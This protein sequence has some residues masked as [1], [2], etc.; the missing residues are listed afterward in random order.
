MMNSKIETHDVL[1]I[2]HS[3]CMDGF[4]SAWVAKRYFD[5]ANTSKPIKV[6]FIPGVYSN[7]PP[8]VKGKTVY[9]LDFSY[10]REVMEQIVRDA[11]KVIILDHH[12]TAIDRLETLEGASKVFDITRSGARITWDYFFP[13]EA[14]P[15]N[16]LHVEDRDLWKFNLPF[17]REIISAIF[18]YPYDFAVWDTLMSKDS[19]VL[20]AEGIH[21]ERKH[22]KDIN[23]LIGV[24]KRPMRIGGY[25]VNVANLPYTMSS[26]AGQILIDSGEPFGVCYYDTPEGRLFSLRSNGDF[27]VAK[28]AEQYG[29]GGHKNA[30]GFRVSYDLARKMEV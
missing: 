8:D 3:N 18:S 26:D 10:T 24:V 14:P 23:E 29:G 11:S 5:R 19:T 6:S 28:I 25:L 17:T 21:I 1:V 16:L 22:F 9:I 13:Q 4:T 20:A 27:N 2:F 15:V 30:S 12:Q 7:P